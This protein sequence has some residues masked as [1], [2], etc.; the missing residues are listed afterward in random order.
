MKLSSIK[1]IADASF[2][3]YVP[4]IPIA[5]PTSAFFSA[6][7]SFVPSPVTATMWFYSFKPTIIAYLSLG[8]DLAITATF[9]YNYLKT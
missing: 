5:K 9:G 7:A 3:T 8:L 4:A 2:A 1:I 6:G